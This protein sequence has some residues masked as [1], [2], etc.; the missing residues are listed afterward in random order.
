MKRAALYS[1]SVLLVAVAAGCG[2]TTKPTPSP[3][4]VTPS[5]SLVL[6]VE[7]AGGPASAF[8]K[9]LAARVVI[10]NRNGRALRVLHTKQGQ[11]AK[12]KLPP[13]HYSVGFGRRASSVN[14]LGGCRPKVATVT[15]GHTLRYTLWYGCA[16][17]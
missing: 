16:Y 4:R 8:G 6:G 17:D 10:F 9:L 3:P 7:L 11:T 15:A 12:V 14:R 5:G 2:G 1:L 13:G